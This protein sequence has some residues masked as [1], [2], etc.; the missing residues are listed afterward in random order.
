MKIKQTMPRLGVTSAAMLLA[1]FVFTGCDSNDGE[2]PPGEG[3]EDGLPGEDSDAEENGDEQG[4]QPDARQD[5]LATAELSD[6]EGEGAGQVEFYDLD[7]GELDVEILAENFEPGFYGFHIHGVGEC[8]LDSEAPD[9]PEETGD[10]LSAGGHLAGEDEEAEHPEHAGDLPVL[11]VNEDGTGQMSLVTDRLNEEL[12]L[13]D[14]GSAVIIHADEDN[15][16]NVPDRYLD[17]GGPD[18]DT[19]ST[20]DAGDRLACGVIEG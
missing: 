15:F 12:L 19:L 14:D 16:A 20:G 18:D 9:D 5:P 8:E 1:A 4:A 2:G 7:G 10:F 11:L 6:A 17:D 3:I 13:D